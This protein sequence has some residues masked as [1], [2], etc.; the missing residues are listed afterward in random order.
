MHLVSEREEEKRYWLLSLLLL[1]LHI[2]IKLSH[3]LQKQAGEI[4]KC[5]SGALANFLAPERL[6]EWE[7]EKKKKLQNK[8]SEVFTNPEKTSFFLLISRFCA[9]QEKATETIDSANKALRMLAGQSAEKMGEEGA[10]TL[11]L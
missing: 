11:T 9:F 4:R 6:K 10:E 8:K 5:E 7:E 2:I 3:F 1:K